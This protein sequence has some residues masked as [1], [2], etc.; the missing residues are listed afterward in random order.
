[1]RYVARHPW[2][3]LLLLASACSVGSAPPAPAVLERHV[4]FLAELDPPRDSTHPESLSLAAAYIAAE[5]LAAGG[6]VRSQE[7]VVD[8][9]RY[10]N[11]EPLRKYGV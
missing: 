8:E 7:L 3:A 2:A 11:V 10:R 1:M 6:D 9:K 4:R 5:F